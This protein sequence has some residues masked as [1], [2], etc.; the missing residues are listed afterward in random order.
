[1]LEVQSTLYCENRHVLYCR[2]NLGGG[3]ALG[4]GGG[5]TEHVPDTGQ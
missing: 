2:S 5:A 3:A 4:E 1:M